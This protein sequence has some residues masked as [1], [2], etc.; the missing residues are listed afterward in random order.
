[1]RGSGGRVARG[2][3]TSGASANP[4]DVNDARQS[5]VMSGVVLL[6]IG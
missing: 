6:V 4:K 3:L 1:M 5:G 2:Y